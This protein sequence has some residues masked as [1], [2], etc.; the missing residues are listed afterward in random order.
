L[1]HVPAS[2][3]DLAN[4]GDPWPTGL[5]K[6]RRLL[7]TLWIVNGGADGRKTTEADSVAARA[8]WDVNVHGLT[9]PGRVS[10]VTVLTQLRELGFVSGFDAVEGGYDVRLAK[11]VA[12]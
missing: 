1:I 9:R 8:V 2:L 7:V 3:F 11:E 5:A 10:V 4:M 12:A 6:A